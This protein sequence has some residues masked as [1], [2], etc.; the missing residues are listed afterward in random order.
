[1]RQM[2]N[3]VIATRR[4]RKLFAIALSFALVV[5][6]LAGCSS[7]QQS[8]SSQAASTQASSAA[9]LALDNQPV[10]RDPSFGGVYIK[11]TIDDFNKLGFAYGDSVDISFSNGYELKDV[12]YYN[13][14]YVNV[15]DPVLVAYPGYPYIE[16]AVSFGDPLWDTAGLT[17]NDTATVTLNKAGVYLNIQEAF[18]ITYTDN[19][20]D[21]SSDVVFANFRACT[22][23]SLKS[24]VLYR[25]ASP[26]DN[27]HNRVPYVETLMAQAGMAYVLNLSDNAEEADAFVAEDTKDGIDVSYFNKLRDAGCTG[28][29][30]LS[31]N[32]PS[33]SYAKTLVAGLV[34]M[35]QHDGPYLV[36]CVEGKDRTGFVC[37]LLEALCGATY[38]EMQADYMTTFDNYYGITKQ[39]DP[40][41]YDAISDLNFDGMLRVLANADENADLTAIDYTGHARD[42][43]RMGGMTDEQIDALVKKLTS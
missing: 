33:A 27:E 17:E 15:G 29:L 38:D 41:K 3:D 24:N 10:M 43:L 30:D 1:M 25:S 26:I 14:Y 39:S 36:H 40:S 22:G 23:G 18:D 16:A 12:P 8:A 13:G 28:F 35:S 11:I 2:M 9:A 4:F 5:A 34:E 21:Y 20:A 19:R 42:Y 31:A 7:E 37:L 32:Y 6:A